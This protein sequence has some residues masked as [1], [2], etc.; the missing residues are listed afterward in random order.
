MCSAEL[1][2]ALRSP[3]KQQI[4]A[5]GGSGSTL[6]FYPWCYRTCRGSS[7]FSP[8]GGGS[9]VEQQCSL[10]Q[11]KL[12]MG[13]Q[14][15]GR[16]CQEEAA[17]N[18]KASAALMG[19]WKQQNGPIFQTVQTNWGGGYKM[20]ALIASCFLKAFMWRAWSVFS[21]IKAIHLPPLF[22][23]FSSFFYSC[24][25]CCNSHHPPD[26]QRR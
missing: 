4:N 8:G 1:I 21:Y 17:A 10:F 7:T 5:N 2:P 12:L 23:F 11:H 3:L 13:H 6:D 20:Q 22:F 19:V 16:P 24:T 15:R 25:N 9:A 26:V 18:A 14:C